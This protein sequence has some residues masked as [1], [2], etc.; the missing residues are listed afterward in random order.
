M[1]V[2]TLI[3]YQALSH[4]LVLDAD[5]LKLQTLNIFANLAV[6]CILLLAPH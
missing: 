2:T 5:L 1:L 6:G 3:F 4:V